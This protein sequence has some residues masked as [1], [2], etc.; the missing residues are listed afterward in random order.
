[1][2]SVKLGNMPVGSIVKLNENGVAVNFMVVHQ[3]LPSSDYDSSCDGTWLL[4]R[5]HCTN[6]MAYGSTTDYATSKIHTWF[7]NTYLN[8][9]DANIRDAIKEVKIP[10]QAG[11]TVMTGSN[12][13]QTKIFAP[14]IIE[15]GKKASSRYNV[16]GAAWE[17]F[18]SS[19]TLIGSY[20][21]SRYWWTRSPSTEEAGYIACA[22]TTASINSASVKVLPA[23]V[24]PD[25]LSVTD[26]GTITTNTPPTITSTIGSSGVNLGTKNEGFTFS[27][28]VADA[29]GDTLTV[30]EQLD[31]ETKRTFTTTGGTYTFET[32]NN[33]D[34]NFLKILNGT[35]T[36]SIAVSDGK[37]G[38]TFTATFT[39]NVT[40]LSFTLETPLDADD[41]ITRAVETMIAAIP[42]GATVTIEVCNNG[43]DA[44]PTWEDVTGQVLQG[45]KFLFKNTAKTAANW[46]YNVRVNVKRGTATGDCYVVSMTGFFD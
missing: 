41:Q 1:M 19:A 37:E 27:Y 32:A 29:D 25:T 17:Y 28:T 46:G 42:S 20:T 34:H 6:E 40:S 15:V 36:I 10:Y 12:G 2:A 35:H 16:I 9:F 45:S 13:L 31:G 26:D 30:M 44:S 38:A 5:D 4:R 3:G 14:S 33:S 8:R 7:N 18:A 43:Y 23:L 39:K 22:N 21:S 11:S 24:L